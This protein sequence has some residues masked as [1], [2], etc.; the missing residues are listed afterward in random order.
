[1]CVCLGAGK[2]DLSY[3]LG[4]NFCFDL[5][6]ILLRNRVAAQFNMREFLSK[7]P[8]SVQFLARVDEICCEETCS[9][10]TVCNANHA[11]HCVSRSCLFEQIEFC[12][13][14]VFRVFL[15]VWTL[16]ACTCSLCMHHTRTIWKL[17]PWVRIYKAWWRGQRISK[18]SSLDF[19]GMHSLLNFEHC[20]VD[21][22]SCNKMFTATCF[23]MKSLSELAT[24]RSRGFENVSVTFIRPTS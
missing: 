7:I 20:G 2:P 5:A 16:G 17:V 13:G 14:C 21:Y 24:A 12:C 11:R 10:D 1:V 23:E 18:L 4:Y 8:L 15:S 3:Q 22:C 6:R 19:R 9:I